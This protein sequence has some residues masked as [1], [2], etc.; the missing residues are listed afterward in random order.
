MMNSANANSFRRRHEAGNEFVPPADVQI[1]T[2]GGRSIPAHSAILASASPV[3]E[4]MLYRCRISWNSQRIIRI[5]GVP[6]DAVL[7]LV[8]FFYSSREGEE[9]MEKYG[10][11]LLVLS[12]AYQV[13]RLK[14]WCEEGVAARL[15]AEVVV[16]VLK[17]AKLCD[18]PWLYQRCMRLVAKDFAAVTQSEGWRFIQKHD[19]L[20]ELEILQFLQDA[21]QRKKR[22]MREK[23]DQEMYQLLSEAVECLQHICS[24]GCTVVGPHDGKPPSRSKGPCKFH[25]CGG[26][27][28]LICHFATC[29]RKLSPGG[30]T[31]CKRMWQLLQ[32][33]SSICDQSNSCKVP[34]CK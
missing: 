6:C 24:D 22:W 18:A 33:H 29:S 26:L 28:F 34:L 7:A 1:V 31:H 15:R 4:K 12:H 13:K 2:S 17:L 20:L 21:D 11:H 30:C 23:R 25:T 8:Q 5:L 27:Q 10:M 32:L 14:R 19:P 3:L 16:D 9:A